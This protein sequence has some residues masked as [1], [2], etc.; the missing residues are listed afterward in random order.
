MLFSTPIKDDYMVFHFL[1]G[2]EEG[3]SESEQA[4]I[5]SATP[6]TKEVERSGW[7]QEMAGQGKPGQ[8]STGW[9]VWPQN[10]LP[11]RSSGRT[12][13]ETGRWGWV[14]VAQG[15]LSHPAFTLWQQPGGYMPIFK[16]RK[17]RLSKVIWKNQHTAKAKRTKQAHRFSH[18]LQN[19]RTVSPED[20]KMTFLHKLTLYK[21]WLMTASSHSHWWE[22]SSPW[23][24]PQGCI[25][26]HCQRGQRY[27][28]PWLH[29]PG[30]WP[31]GC[32]C[33]FS[34]DRGKEWW[35]DGGWWSAGNWPYQV[36]LEH[37]V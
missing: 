34:L 8:A 9:W 2:Q 10:L 4:T 35:D 12:L 13:W 14:G 17:Q 1:Q 33:C 31:L 32:E 23:H 11:A 30:V 15:M 29:S 28:G 22:S 37:D 24:K 21:G 16:M 6:G 3:I 25:H 26:S 18:E 20:P 7:P 27:S 36:Y 19:S 5:T